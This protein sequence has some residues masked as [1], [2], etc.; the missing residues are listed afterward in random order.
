M[1]FLNPVNWPL[2]LKISL[3]F[4]V[5]SLI[6]VVLIAYLSFSGSANTLQNS[7][8]RNIE[9]LA[10]SIADRLDQL[11]SDNAIAAAQLG[12]DTEIIALLS[13]P[14]AASETVQ[15]SVSDSLSRILVS[16]PQYEYVYLMDKTGEVV[17]SKQAASVTSLEGQDFS[18]RTYF[19]EA[20]KGNV[21]I[22]AFAAGANKQLGFYFASPV[23]GSDGKPLGVSVVKLKGEAVTDI[24]GQFKSGNTGYAFLVDQNGMIISHPSPN[25]Q[26]NTLM[27]LSQDAELQAGQRYLV[28]G[29]DNAT[30][31]ESCNVESLNLPTLAEAIENSEK[32]QHATYLSPEDNSEQIIGIAKTRQLNSTVIVNESMSE[33]TAP[34]NSLALRALLSVLVISILAIIGGI[35]LARYITQPLGKLSAV[36]QSIQQ[37]NSPQLDELSPITRHGDEVGHLAVV[38]NEMLKSLEARVKELHALNVISRKISSSFNVGTTLTLVLNSVRKVVPYDRALLMLYESEGELFYTR[39]VGD[40][41]GFYLNRVWSKEESPVVRHKYEGYLQRFFDKQRNKTMVALKPDLDEAVE[42]AA[43]PYADE[44]GDFVA[45]SYL[46]MP[47]MYKDEMV[48]VIELAS[49]EE[50]R[51]N[52][53]HSHVL[54]LIAGQAAVALRNAMEVEELQAELRRQIDALKIEVDESKKQKN[55]EE[56]V[57]SDYFQELSSKAD[58]IRQRREEE[59]RKNRESA[60]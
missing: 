28:P 1:R 46:G 17:V 51:F 33:F 10:I 52:A 43:F 38:F 14:T 42:A 29:C 37:G 24:V 50:D 19:S 40:G 9:L 11:F 55:V 31:L 41:R 12:S 47:M 39:A 60:T 54:E 27:P 49:E 8:Y 56:I 21:Y 15:T 44:W 30:N 53:N 25:W 2:L 34:L 5:P 20:M 16:N 48:G 7:E 18:S 59:Q 57:E 36:A 23:L 13:D 26:Y 45:R 3:G 58:R 32:S 6:S 4:L 22:D 35:L